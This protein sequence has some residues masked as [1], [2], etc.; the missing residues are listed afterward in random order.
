M[1]SGAMRSFSLSS[2]SR[3]ICW[4]SRAESSYTGAAASSGLFSNSLRSLDDVF[5]CPASAMMTAS[6]AG[7]SR[8]VSMALAKCSP[9]PRTRIAR[10]PPNMDMAC[11]SS[12]S[13][14]GSSL[15]A[16]SSRTTT[17][18]GS[19]PLPITQRTSLRESSET[20]PGSD[21]C[22]STA[23][24]SP[25]ATFFNRSACRGGLNMAMGSACGGHPRGEAGADVLRHDAGR[26]LFRLV[27]RLNVGHRLAGL[28]V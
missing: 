9:A 18:M 15:Q 14:A 22:T 8:T 27:Q 12:T 2:V 6:P 25:A 5:S 16:S 4:M 23:R 21:P 20:P 17:D 7:R 19:S 10:R 26:R 11:A 24:R 1:A 13:R 3:M 28:R